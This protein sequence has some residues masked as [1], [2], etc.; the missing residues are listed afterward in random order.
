MNSLQ[1]VLVF[2]DVSSDEDDIDRLFN[3][4]EQVE[5]PASLVD[6]ILA[7]VGKIARDQQQEKQLDKVW[8]Q[9]YGPFM[10]D[11]GKDPS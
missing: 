10:H 3:Q 9:I 11:E 2:E 8:T 1:S 7:S 5:P 4:L 6:S